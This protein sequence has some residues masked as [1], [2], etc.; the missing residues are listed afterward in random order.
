MDSDTHVSR[1][2]EKGALLVGF[3]SLAAAV[4]VARGSP[5]EAYELSIY[6]GTPLGF[7][8]GTGVALAVAVFV[9]LGSRGGVRRL[10]LVLGG[11]ATLAIASLPVVRSYYFY[12]AG[13]S[14]THLGWAKDIAAGRLSILEFL[15]PGTHT[16]AVFLADVTGMPLTRALLVMV[17]AFT[18]VFLLFVPLATW[19]L[20]RDRR[21]SA[22][23]ALSAFLLLPIN[24]ISVFEMAHPTSQAI[25]FFPLVLYLLARYVTGT[26]RGSLLVG[27]PTGALLALAS[28][29]IVL[30]H[31]QQAAN[32]LVVFGSVLALQ[33]LARWVGGTAAD[34]S[35]VAFQTAVIG[36]AFLLWAPRHERASGA[37]TALVEMVQGGADIGSDVGAQAV[38]LS[39]IGGSVGI[40]FLKLFLVSTVFAGLTAL[41]VLAGFRGTV[42][43]PDQRAFVRYFG[44]GLIPLLGL[45]GAF[46]FVSY[47]GLHFRQL[48]FVMVLGTVLGAV[49]LTR[50]L[51]T[52]AGRFSPTTAKA[53]V[54]VAFVVMLA[55]SVPTVYASPYMYQGSSHVTEAQTTGYA[56]AFEYAGDAPFL[57]VR[58]TGERFADATMGYE[59]S[60]AS[61]PTSGSLY[62]NTNATGENFTG[63]YLAD[64]LPGRYLTVT[65]ATRQQDVEVYRGL[66]FPERGFESLDSTPG[67]NRVHANRDVQTYLVNGTA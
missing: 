6:A 20:T 13:D 22:V 16:I 61:A 17:M 21:A 33:L 12:G 37:T 10:A 43:D 11:T 25:L 34:H 66:R 45:F 63:A 62:A 44:F 47:A 36:G 24:N 3:V 28:V 4:L 26:D 60:R 29:A 18:A 58:G 56:N 52:L 57:G 67:L 41:V 53:V 40:I 42:E 27:T 8:V 30:V 7:W 59:E 55:L 38:S 5:P 14:L 1:S 54:G 39:T 64:N 23:A 31:P 48:G 2:R 65:D 32:A 49:A 46:L 35:L 51:D 15:Y 19:A 9:G 50:G